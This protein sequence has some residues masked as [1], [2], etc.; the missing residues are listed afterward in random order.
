[1]YIFKI[2]TLDSEIFYQIADSINDCLVTIKETIKNPH[3]IEVIADFDAKSG[4]YKDIT[5]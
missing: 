1:M 2:I 5:K 3:I 4:M